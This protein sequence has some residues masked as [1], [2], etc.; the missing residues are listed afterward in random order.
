[1]SF[2]PAETVQ[3]AL[4]YEF[5]SICILL[6]ECSNTVREAL[7]ATVEK[8]SD[9]AFRG[10]ESLPTRESLGYPI[11]RAVLSTKVR[12]TYV[13]WERSLPG[14]VSRRGEEDTV[15]GVLY[16]AIFPYI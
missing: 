5:N 3:S 11:I 1:M 13:L 9:E 6:A 8:G 10:H 14:V 2:V 4:Q 16:Y 12:L 7:S 15:R